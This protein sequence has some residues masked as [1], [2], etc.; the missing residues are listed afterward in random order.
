MFYTRFQMLISSYLLPPT[1]QKHLISVWPEK[2]DLQLK[3][4]KLIPRERPKHLQST[5][6]TLKPTYRPTGF[7]K[8]HSTNTPVQ[9]KESLSIQSCTRSSSCDERPKSPNPLPLIFASKL[10][11]GQNLANS[12]GLDSHNSSIS[13]PPR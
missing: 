2:Q 8:S 12:F 6:S 13:S 4:K 7:Y 10:K 5:T 3:G 9:S 11:N 1:L